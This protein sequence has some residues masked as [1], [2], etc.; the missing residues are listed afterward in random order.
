[1]RYGRQTTDPK[2]HTVQLRINDAT[3]DYLEKKSKKRGISVSELV[4][5][6]LEK[7]MRESRKAGYE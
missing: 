3:K 1:M 7:D 4:R 5:D 2:G 6:I